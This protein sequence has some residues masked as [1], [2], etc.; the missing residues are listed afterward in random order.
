MNIQ[1]RQKPLVIVAAVA[2][3]L[4][5][6]DSVIRKPLVESWKSR[7]D[8]I[9]K[10]RHDVDMDT[11]LLNQRTSITARWNKMQT[12]ALPADKSEAESKVLN[13]L[14]TWTRESDIR[15]DRRQP[16]WRE[17]E[18]ST[19]FELS[20][21]ATGGI[22]SIRNF[23]FAMERDLPKLA[24]R[25]EQLDVSRR[26]NNGQQIALAMQLTGL[27]LGAPNNQSR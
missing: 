11:R 21:D 5:V 27:V 9:V 22:V 20:I 19:I 26:D 14:E 7:R 8:R 15:I 2:L 17:E 12:N 18:D 3:A 4:L 10:L 1:N 25:I 23:L 6:G 13:A 16:Q 24:L